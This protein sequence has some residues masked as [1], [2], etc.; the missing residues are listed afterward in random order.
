MYR[1]LLLCLGVRLGEPPTVARI[2][3]E[4][5][6]RTRASTFTSLLPRPLPTALT[7]G[8]VEEVERRI[9]NLELFD[10]VAVAITGPALRVRVREKHSLI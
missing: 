10:D 1:L 2:E 4:G 7:P 8:D 9:R 6:D 3:V 5:N